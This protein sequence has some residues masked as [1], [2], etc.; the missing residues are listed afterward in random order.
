MDQ[1][2]KKGYAET[3]PI[4]IYAELLLI[5]RIKSSDF[6]YFSTKEN[7]SIR[8]DRLNEYSVRQKSLLPLCFEDELI[9]PDAKIIDIGLVKTVTSHTVIKT[10]IYTTVQ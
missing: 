4:N 9:K 8:N 5:Y 10:S 2:D 6:N 3:S 7:E 1:I